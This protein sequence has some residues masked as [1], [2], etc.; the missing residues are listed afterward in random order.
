MVMLPE[1]RF[2]LVVDREHRLLTEIL[3]RAEELGVSGRVHVLPMVPPEEVV[4]FIREADVG[5]NPLARYPGGDI[6]LPNKLF[7]YLHAGLPMVVSDSPTMADFVR[8]H[9]LGEVAPVDDARAWADAIER[10]LAPPHY[11]DRVSDWEALKEEWCWERQAE[12]LL[13]VYRRLLGDALPATAGRTARAS[14]GLALMA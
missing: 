11:R 4:P 1:I 3:A 5:V 2:A 13:A 9:G 14:V 6:A 12:T 8:R 10:A 7:E